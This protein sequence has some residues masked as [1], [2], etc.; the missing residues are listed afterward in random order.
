MRV[1]YSYLSP[2]FLYTL[3]CLKIVRVMNI[4]QT[5]R[6]KAKDQ[7]GQIWHVVPQNA[8][9]ILLLTIASAYK[10]S[11]VQDYQVMTSDAPTIAIADYQCSR[12][13]TCMRYAIAGYV[14][15]TILW[16][17]WITSKTFG[18]IT[19]AHSLWSNAGKTWE[20][21]LTSYAIYVMS[22]AMASQLIL[23][24]FF[25]APVY[26]PEMV[27]ALITSCGASIVI[28]ITWLPKMFLIYNNKFLPS[29]PH[30]SQSPPPIDTS[31]S[32]VPGCGK[33]RE[34]REHSFSGSP[35]NSPDS[36]C[37]TPGS[38]TT[39]SPTNS[40]NVTNQAAFGHALRAPPDTEMFTNMPERLSLRLS[41]NESPPSTL[42]KSPGASERFFGYAGC[43]LCAYRDQ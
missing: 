30:P 34:H 13:G 24:Q 17:V 29:S 39:L 33:H 36:K 31:I 3:L 22:A 27:S 19:L 1:W 9:M 43:W 21:R 23:S 18:A 28:S 42:Q 11:E 12:Y 41:V 40:F 35:K 20:I 8:G 16:G 37:T 5:I 10:G 38:W 2:Y 6:V 32:R 26:V 14:A 4:V 7:G 15:S 25:N